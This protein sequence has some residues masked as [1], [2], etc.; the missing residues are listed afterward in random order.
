[1]PR[2]RSISYPTPQKDLWLDSPPALLDPPELPEEMWEW[3]RIIHS[4]A[5]QLYGVSPELW[6]KGL[7]STGNTT[8]LR[9]FLIPTPSTTPSRTFKSISQAIDR[10]TI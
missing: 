2:N 6:Q 8:G 5:Q 10:K 7:V 3:I 4:S 9:E 1:M